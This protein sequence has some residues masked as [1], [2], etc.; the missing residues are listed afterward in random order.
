M[1]TWHY[2]PVIDDDLSLFLIEVHLDNDAKLTGWSERPSCPSGNDQH[3]LLLD[4]ALMAGA[5]ARWKPVRLADLTVGMVFER[6][7]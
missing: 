6:R 1:T 4:L 7:A 5:V 3:E 2:L